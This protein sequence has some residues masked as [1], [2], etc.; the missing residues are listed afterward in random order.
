MK[1]LILMGIALLTVMTNAFAQL[2]SL[3]NDLVFTPV[4]PCRIFDTR[5]SQGGTGPIPAAGTKGFA[6]WGQTSF[7][8]QGGAATNCG[9]VAAANTEAVAVNLTVVLPTTG[10]FI[11]AY[12]TGAPLPVAA[13]V[14]FNA[15]DV[16][17]NFAIV[18]VQQ[19]GAAPS[20]NVYSTSTVDVVGDV[21]GYYS[22]P[23]ATALECVNTTP[24]AIL[25]D[26][27]PI[28][29]QYSNF[30]S[31]GACPAGY[32]P[33][34]FHCTVSDV[35]GSASEGPNGYCVGNAPVNTITLGAY[36]TCCR[37]PGR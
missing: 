7:T 22:K 9:V 15:G 8:A 32:S 28:G 30:L 16:K 11:T 19:T 23:V 36:R 3:S 37:I 13:T 17:G 24:T 12:P 18:K 4:T 5:P 27:N 6:V 34:S 1:K 25:I 20:L 21:V 10:G 2:G 14:N 31:P 29:A 26:A 35:R 33:T